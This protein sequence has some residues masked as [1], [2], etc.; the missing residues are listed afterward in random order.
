MILSK[1]IATACSNERQR[2]HTVRSFSAESVPQQVIEQ[3]I[4][5][6]ASAPS[7]ANH[8]P[9]HFVAISDPKVKQQ[10]RQEAELQETGFYPGR[11]DEKWLQA[12]K[13]LATDAHK[14]YL[15]FAPWL[16]V[17]FSQKRGGFG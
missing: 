4:Q 5:I 15:E 11:A 16:I 8:Q 6:A 10:I 12:L 2:R 9:W 3:V 1:S 7:G 14:P 17:I 13:P